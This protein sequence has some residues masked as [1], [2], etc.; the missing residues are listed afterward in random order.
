[1]GSYLHY[2]PT[3]NVESYVILFDVNQRKDVLEAKDV[4]HIADADIHDAM[5]GASKSLNGH[6]MIARRMIV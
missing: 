4:Q 3:S 5:S 6:V 1:V 2:V